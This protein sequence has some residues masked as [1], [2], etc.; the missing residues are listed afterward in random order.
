MVQKYVQLHTSLLIIHISTNLLE[1]PH[2]GHLRPLADPA[3]LLIQGD[4]A[5][6]RGAATAGAEHLWKGWGTSVL[7]KNARRPTHGTYLGR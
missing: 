6:S 3:S 1:F 7:P 5:Q 2:S 4:P